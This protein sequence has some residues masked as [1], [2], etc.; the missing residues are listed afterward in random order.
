MAPTS[1]KALLATLVL[2]LLAAVGTAFL[3]G[4]EGPAPAGPDADAGHAR[5]AD[6]STADGS[7]RRGNANDAA[8]AAAKAA[9]GGARAAAAGDF[10][11]GRP[12]PADARW[13]DLVVVDKATG[14]PQPGAVVHWY[15]DSAHE[16][17]G[18]GD[19]DDELW[20]AAMQQLFQVVERAAGKAGWRTLADAD[21]KARVTLGRHWTNVAAT[22]GALYGRLELRDNSVPPAGGWRVELLPDRAVT[23]RVVDDAGVPCADVPIGLVALDRD[24]QDEVLVPGD[25]PVAHTDADGR[26]TVPHL[27]LTCDA[28]AETPPWAWGGWRGRHWRQRGDDAKPTPVWRVRALLAGSRDKGVAFDPAATPAEP[29]ELRLPPTGRLR[30]RAESAGRPVATFTAAYAS[31]S[32]DAEGGAS[33]FDFGLEQRVGADGAALFARVALGARFDVYTGADGGMHGTFAGPT[34]KDQLVDVVL[35]PADDVVVLAGRLLAPDRQPARNVRISVRA[36]GDDLWMH[37]TTKTD[38]DGRFV[39]NLGSLD[40]DNAT[41]VA[42]KL[43][44]DTIVKDAPPQ[45]AEVVGRSLRHGREELGDVVLGDAPL[46]CGGVVN[47]GGKP[48]AGEVHLN[49]ERFRPPQDGEADGQWGWVDGQYVHKDKEGRF[50][51][52]GVPEPGRYRLQC[53]AER[54]LPFEPI[55]FRLGAADLAVE[56]AIGVPLAA[57]ALLAAK[58]PLQQ[59]RFSL[60]PEQPPAKKPAA[61]GKDGADE[62][63]WLYQGQVDGVES[64]RANVRWDTLPPGSYTLRVELWTQRRELLSIAG[65]AVPPAATPD[66]R[67]VDIDLRQTLRTVELSL[68]AAD[69]KELDECYGA[70][71]PSASSSEWRG[72]T[73]WQNRTLLLLPPGPYELLV[74]V[75]GHR[76]LPVRGDGDKA[77]ARMEPWPRVLV[78]VTGI[79]KLPKET[80]A[81]GWLVGPTTAKE[82]YETSWSGGDRSDFLQAGSDPQT[83]EDGVARLPISDGAHTLHLGLFNEL[84]G[85]EIALAAPVTILPNQTAITVA[86]PEAVWQKALAELPKGDSTPPPGLQLR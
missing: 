58:A 74:C 9:D 6:A 10:G 61:A 53:G 86:V 28:T 49:V 70:V 40:G 34:A 8:E 54:A 85:G 20:D 13:V 43:W 45:R 39:V 3:H 11:S 48:F 57:S 12:L 84:G 29:I 50:T 5:A 35:R 21:G 25:T 32:E 71:F 15:D 24:K 62:H 73:I 77:V 68:L 66:P 23:V 78:H 27:Q 55:E 38:G 42:P 36:V 1:Q 82:R 51:V 47:V 79:P 46:L 19:D 72:E 33:A 22:H 2:V 69:G 4:E 83:I 37:E 65:V 31:R 75:S 44:I 30:V 59:L 26:A 16:F 18:V 60:V 80:W 17:L 56:L 64:G 63:A 41:A 81:R 76:P 52:R 7:F 14:A 67:L